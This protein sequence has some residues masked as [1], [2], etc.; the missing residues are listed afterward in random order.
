ML[1]TRGR[2]EELS[3]EC[4]EAHSKA[5]TNVKENDFPIK[6]SKEDHLFF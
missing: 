4:Y 5:R 2:H 3:K 6:K 1:K